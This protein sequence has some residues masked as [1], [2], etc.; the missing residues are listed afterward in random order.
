MSAA[1]LSSAGDA[2]LCA[3][4][5][6]AIGVLLALRKTQ[7]THLFWGPALYGPL[8]AAAAELAPGG[9][10]AVWR[11]LLATQT[12]GALAA[13]VVWCTIALYVGMGGALLLA[14]LTQRPAW[15]QALRAQPGVRREWREVGAARSRGQPFALRALGPPPPRAPRALASHLYDPTHA[16]PPNPTAP[17]TLNPTQPRP[18]G[19]SSAHLPGLVQCRPQRRDRRQVRSPAQ[20]VAT[21][22]PARNHHASST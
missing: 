20:P 22:Y 1:T 15:L 4:A 21:T 19:P 8:L 18:P 6:A 7:L 2:W 16:T 17:V 3:G 5:W 10:P 13:G 11:T 14:D 12:G 9:A